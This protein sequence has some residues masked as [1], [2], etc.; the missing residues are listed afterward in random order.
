[1]RKHLAAY[2]LL[3]LI[4]LPVVQAQD[5][6]AALNKRVQPA[7]VILKTYDKERREIAIATGFFISGGVLVTNKHVISDAAFVEVITSTQTSIDADFII[8]Q[9]DKSDLAV[10]TLSAGHRSSQ[11]LT[12]ANTEPDIGARVIVI[13][14]P[15]GLGWTL[16][17]GIVSGWRDFEDAG[18]R[19]QISADIS[20]GSSGSPVLNMRGEVVGVVEASQTNGQRL[21]FAIPTASLKTLLT[22]QA[23]PN[24]KKIAR[25]GSK[26]PA[27]RA[28]NQKEIDF[29]DVVSPAMNTTRQP[30]NLDCPAEA[31]CYR[32]VVGP[33]NRPSGWTATNI[34]FVRGDCVL[35]AAL[36]DVVL[37]NHAS[38]SPSG[39]ANLR[40]A[41]KPMAAA[42]TGALIGLIG[43]DN[44]D[45]LLLGRRE[46]FVARRSGTLFLTVNVDNIKATSGI[47]WV[48]VAR[49]PQCP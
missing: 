17:E 49:V 8:A 20:P 48:L 40:D 7:V 36:G 42:P 30:Y 24:L 32:L 41:D 45:F 14:N 37:P 28:D 47:F 33:G 27:R 4:G 6:L 13:G 9:D 19:L 38:V 18:L 46:T 15:R 39:Q 1:M 11:S 22:E 34:Q 21:N 26:P 5:D 25:A 12:L 2:I 10:L 16:S 23:I 44:E 31:V 35:V 29:S 3:L 43:D